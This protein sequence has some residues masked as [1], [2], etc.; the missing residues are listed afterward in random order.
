MNRF[1]QFLTTAAV[2]VLVTG[3]ASVPRAEEPPLAE[4]AVLHFAD[5]G[6]IRTWRNDGRDALLIEGRN[7][8]WYR[9]TFFG[10]CHE[11]PFASA[12]YFVTDTTGD[13]DK[14]SSVIV[15]GERCYFKTFQRTD[16]PDAARRAAGG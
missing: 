5:I 10:A 1:G 4:R 13:L 15:R 3:C 7:G 12:I 16:D 14:F 11:L 8:Q 6:G 9:A 2:A